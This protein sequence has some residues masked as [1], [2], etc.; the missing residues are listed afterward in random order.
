MRSGRFFRARNI[1]IAVAVAA[2]VIMGVVLLGAPATT[3]APASLE[4]HYVAYD[5]EGASMALL[6]L[7]LHRK[8]SVHPGGI[9]LKVGERWK[10]MR[11]V[12][13]NVLNDAAHF[14]KVAFH[15]REG[16]RRAGWVHFPT[17]QTWRLQVKIVEPRAGF[18]GVIVR[19]VHAWS[20]YRVGGFKNVVEGRTSPPGVGR[21]WIVTSDEVNP[22]PG[23]VNDK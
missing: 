15:A 22:L 4:P 9:E 13:T 21:T 18:G 2:L 5:K 7:T 14:T 6:E 12:P 1:V 8:V 3:D 23:I 20:F 11:R 17:N 16:G 19:L 10:R